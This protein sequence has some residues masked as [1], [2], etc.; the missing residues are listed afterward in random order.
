MNWAVPSLNIKDVV[1]K[2]ILLTH[3]P[4]LSLVYPKFG[5]LSPI[6]MYVLFRMLDFELC[7]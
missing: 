4:P 1:F 7:P 6:I 5:I 2:Y 3:Y